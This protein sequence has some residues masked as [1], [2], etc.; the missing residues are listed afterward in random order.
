[1]IGLIHKFVILIHEELMV[2]VLAEVD[3]VAVSLDSVSQ[4][5]VQQGGRQH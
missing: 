5:G 4:L 1:M 3:E 2:D